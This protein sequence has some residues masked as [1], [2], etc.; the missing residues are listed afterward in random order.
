MGYIPSRKSV[1]AQDKTL[2]SPLMSPFVNIL[3]YATPRGPSAQWPQVSAALYTA[4][5][6]VMLDQK[7][8]TAAAN[9]A[10]AS[11]DSALK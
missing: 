5:Q 9:E 3:T 6:E 2:E 10:Q 11:I 1:A 7:T 4:E 8:P